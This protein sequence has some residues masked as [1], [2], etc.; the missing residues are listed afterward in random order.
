MCVPLRI[1]AR[2]VLSSHLG[3]DSLDTETVRAQMAE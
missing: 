2:I 3:A 1:W